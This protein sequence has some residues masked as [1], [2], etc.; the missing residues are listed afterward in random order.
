MLWTMAALSV[1]CGVFFLV[2]VVANDNNVACCEAL[3][4]FLSMAG[5]TVG[6]LYWTAA[7]Y[8][9]PEPL[10]SSTSLSLEVP[11]QDTV[12]NGMY[13]TQRLHGHR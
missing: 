1:V 8:P 12:D 9:P 2:A 4:T 7:S 13:H 5:Y 3:A 10:S 6:S 11:S